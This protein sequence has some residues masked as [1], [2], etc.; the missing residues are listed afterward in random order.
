M[1]VARESI[2]EK[3]DPNQIR[4]KIQNLTPAPLYVQIFARNKPQLVVQGIGARLNQA[5]AK[6]FDFVSTPF[7][8]IIDVYNPITQMKQIEPNG[9]AFLFIPKKAH[10]R[11]RYRYFYWDT[12]PIQQPKVGARPHATGLLDLGIDLSSNRKIRIMDMA[13]I[14]QKA[15]AII[16]NQPHAQEVAH[17]EFGNLNLGVK[18]INIPD[19]EKTAQKARDARTKYAIER[20]MSAPVHQAP[21]I[22]LCFSGGG[23]RAMFESLGFTIGLEQTNLLETIS[24]SA[25]LS[26]S[27]WF[28]M[29][30]LKEQGEKNLTQIQTDLQRSLN[31][32]ML[33]PEILKP[34]TKDLQDIDPYR[35]IMQLLYGTMYYPAPDFQAQILATMLCRNKNCTRLGEYTVMDIWAYALARRIFAKH[36]NDKYTFT[37]SSLSEKAKTGLMPIPLFSAIRTDD[38]VY[39]AQVL[40]RRT[41]ENKKPR[42]Y[43]WLEATPFSASFLIDQQNGNTQISRI[44]M[45][46]LGRK[47]ENNKSVKQSK[48]FFK[49]ILNL[50]GDHYHAEP[51]A[52]QLLA[53]FGSVFSATFL[54]IGR[55]QKAIGDALHTAQTIIGHAT[56]LAGIPGM[57]AR[58]TIQKNLKI[59]LEQRNVAS[60]LHL[61]NPVYNAREPVTEIRDGGMYYNLPLPLLFNAGRKLDI[62]IINDASG[63]LHTKFGAELKRFRTYEPRPDYITYQLSQ[64]FL[65]ENAFQEK[66]EALRETSFNGK[67]GLAVFNDPRLPTFEPGKKTLIYVPMITNRKSQSFG[68]KSPTQEYDTFKLQYSGKESSLL[69]D[70]GIDLAHTVSE[71]IKEIIRAR[72]EKM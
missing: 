18:S 11:T 36:K 10:E 57:L 44:P 54:E 37:L 62:I 2:Q 17:I 55:D 72:T 1:A 19:E 50:T 21:R 12:K 47:F 31:K 46:A 7:G 14:T 8:F 39:Y 49:P 15:T 26:G 65:N 64:D 29:K 28:L 23:L 51:S 67:P 22:G 3:A 20:I 6:M 56:L 13:Q 69:I 40:A 32:G 45:W 43:Q 25:A 41:N 24:Y 60:G 16:N 4:I 68:W 52:I 58:N 59:W 30:W 27:T 63:D 66:M 38:D 48:E 61:Y 42:D 9:T 33:E 35:A 70:Y 53:G 5:F 71:E 34:N